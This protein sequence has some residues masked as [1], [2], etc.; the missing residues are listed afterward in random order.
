MHTYTMGNIKRLL[1]C[2][3]F[4]M[5]FLGGILA[6]DT[7]PAEE[8]EQAPTKS[9][10]K[11]AFESGYF[12][13]DQTVTMA[14]AR[15]LEF[16]IQ[17]DFGTIQSHW[18][19]LWGIWGAS[20]IRLG[21][22]YTITKDL[23]VG[24]GTTKN[25][26]LQDFNIKY[27]LA[28]QY[29]EGFPVTIT[30]FGNMA[31]NASNKSTLGNNKIPHL[32]FETVVSDQ[33]FAENLNAQQKVNDSMGATYMSYNQATSLGGAN[34]SD[35]NTLFDYTFKTAYRL[36][37]F[38]EAM[39]ARRFCK[40]FSAQ[41]GVS[42]IHYNLVDQTEMVNNHV[43]GMYNE[44]IN[45][46]GLARIKVSPQS[47]VLLSYS[48][49]VW[50]YLNTAPWPNFGIAWEISTSTHAFQVYLTAANNLVPQEVAMYNKNN[51]YNGAILLG[52]NI[53]RLWTF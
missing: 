34:E 50:T 1:L 23:Q 30:L 39:F 13:A 24:F 8:P 52:F 4:L 36:S 38:A 35:L 11:A 37:Y 40:E 15:T 48:Q 17:H 14:P 20:N 51:P 16:V 47:S 43:N 42:W 12:I 7:I 31:L 53:T 32:N 10:A 33:T 2:H 29:K 5:S 19:N 26:L 44:N 25:K 46:S 45:I 22:S 49:S 18:S 6:Q 28:R 41:L 27:V 9:L 3:I 21:L